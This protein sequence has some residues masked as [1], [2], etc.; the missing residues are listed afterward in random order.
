MEHIG[1]RGRRASGWLAG[2]VLCGLINTMVWVAM[3]APAPTFEVSAHSAILADAATGQVLYEKNG[4]VKLPPASMAKIM[5]MLLIMEEIDAGRLKL[6]DE[7]KVSARASQIGGSQVYL[8]HG[9]VFTVEQL[10]KAVTIHSAND[11]SVALAEHV[12]GAVEAF[13][14]MMNRR[15]QELGMKDTYY[16]NPDG[17]PSEPGRPPTL[18]TPR[19]LV[20]VSRELLKHPKI[21]EWTTITQMTF[22]EKPRTDL[23]N[24]NKL[25]GKY[26][27]LDGLKTGHT[28]EAGW[29]LTATAKRD[30][31]RLI[32]VV[33]RTESEQERQAQTAR[34]L[35]Y[36]F[37][38]FQPVLVA[39]AGEDVGKV[40]VPNGWPGALQVQVRE[41][42]RPLVPRGREEDLQT[43]VEFEELQAPLKA[44]ETVGALVAT[45]DGEELARTD[46]VLPRDVKRANF[47]VRFFRWVAN[48]F[49][50]LFRR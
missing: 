32:S 39:D 10:L 41:P 4:D 45:L 2:L 33:M 8:K 46:V 27:G 15:A 48:L 49:R 47:V 38:G 14:D 25:I 3:A 7:V 36:G 35:D 9:E 29:C 22:R 16:D 5:T 6:T 43:R 50:G 34:L 23:Y 31:V 11:A 44:G 24:T 18:T 28:E 30:G 37:R 42:F 40:K 19:D 26:S 20:K 17:L 12:S 21:L 13:V 1:L